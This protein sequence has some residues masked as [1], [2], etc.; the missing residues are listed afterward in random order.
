MHY[1]N[2]M[3]NGPSAVYSTDCVLL[4]VGAKPQDVDGKCNVMP[5]PSEDEYVYAILV[6]ITSHLGTCGDCGRSARSWIAQTPI[7]NLLL[8]SIAIVPGTPTNFF[9]LHTKSNPLAVQ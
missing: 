3:A 4:D 7:I 5:Q 9:L 2:S 8:P 6:A 1:E